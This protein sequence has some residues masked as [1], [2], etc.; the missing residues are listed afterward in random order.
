MSQCGTESLRMCV[1]SGYLFGGIRIQVIAYREMFGCLGN[2]FNWREGRIF[3]RK[4]MSWG[5]IQISFREL[6]RRHFYVGMLYNVGNLPTNLEI[7]L[8]YFL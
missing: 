6:F 3:R 4:N 7:I 1:C 5:K 2:F 8:K